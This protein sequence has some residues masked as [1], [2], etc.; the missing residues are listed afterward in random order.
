MKYFLHQI[1]GLIGAE[2]EGDA[3]L[4]INAIAKIEEGKPGSISFLANPKYTPFIYSTQASAVIVRKD[5]TP[6]QA[7]QS[8][9]LRVE[10]PY[11][12]FTT[13]L[14]WVEKQQSDSKQGIQAE[15]YVH[16]EAILGKG[17]YVGAFSYISAGCEI[18][19]SVQIYPNV[20]LGKGVKVGA[21]TIIFPHTTIYRNCEV[22]A[23]CI[24]HSGS[25]IGSDGFGFAPQA[26][27]SFRKIPQTGNVVIESEVEIGA[28]CCIDR[29]TVGS[30]RIRSGVKLD[31][32]VQLAH[33]VELGPN[34]VIAA[35]AGIAGSTRLGA[36]CMI[37][38]QAGIVG[39]LSL[40]DGTK[41]DAQSGVNR[42]LST[43]GLA[44]RGSPVQLHRDQLRS[45][46]MFRRLVEMEAR[47]RTLEKAL[48]KRD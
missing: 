5:F 25:R 8:A 4:E 31:N 1:A 35:Q 19:D 9:L 23:N 44:Y 11:S 33:N 27:G 29:A 45:E 32:L 17:T 41:I 46:V 34:T 20:F 10:D 6:Q 37:G 43:P 39:H 38:G 13:L 42:N 47:I 26:D 3:G 22:G 2:I 30:T 18:G 36:H 40:A 24:I 15:A 28:N 14:E 16:P 21:N 7:I 12:A 48:E